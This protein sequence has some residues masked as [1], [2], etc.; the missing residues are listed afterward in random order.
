[1]SQQINIPNND[2]QSRSSN[3][4]R[5]R[6]LLRRGDA[7]AV[8]GDPVLALD[9]RRVVFINRGTAS[10]TGETATVEINGARDV[11]RN[12]PSGEITA[13]QTGIEISGRRSLIVNRGLID[14]GVNGV[15]FVN[16]GRSSGILRNNGTITSDSRAVNIGGRNITV[17]NRG[18]ILGTGDQRNG[19]IYADAT[20]ENLRIINRN[21]GVIDAGE[22]NQ[23]AG[24]ALELGDVANDVVRGTLRNR[25]T[26]QGRGQA[27]PTTGLAGDGIRL[28]SGVEGG[29]TIYRGDLFN[30]GNILSESS[31]GPTSAIRISNGLRFQGRI[32]NTATGV[33]D[34]TQNGLYFGDAEHDVTVLNRGTI[35]SASRAVNIDGTGITLNNIGSILGTGDQRNGT[36]YSD[37]TADNYTIVNTT[38]GV[39]DAG[40]TN[41]GAGIALQTGDAVGDTVTAS[42]QNAGIIQ[43]RGQASATSGQA[44]DGIRIFSG[45]VGGGTTFQ[46]DIT[47]SGSILSES[48]QGPTSAIRFSNGLSFNGTITNQVGGLI[49]GVQNGLYFGTG[50]HNA[51]VNNEGTIQSASRAVNIDGTGIILN[52][53]GSILGTGDQRNGTIYSDATADN[54]TIVNTA[55]GVVDAGAAN[56]GAGIALQTGDITGDTVTASVTNAG[57]I[58]GRGSATGNQSGDGIRIFSGVTDASTT[59]QG[60]I[61]NSGS[62]IATDA[63]VEIVDVTLAGS[64]ENSGTITGTRAA[65]DASAAVGAVTVNNQG[66]LNGDVLLG[67]GNDTYNGS[68]G[69]ING[70]VVGGAGNDSLIGG[71]GSDRL[72]GGVGND[73]LTGNGGADTFVFTPTDLGADIITDFQDGTDILDVSALVAAGA[74]D[75]N[76]L[77]LQQINNDTLITFAPNNTVLLQGIQVNQISA[78]DLVF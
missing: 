68:S 4:N 11:V 6:F 48:T 49:D 52:N 20:A 38:S 60:S 28:Y 18:Q 58:Q 5:D 8:D 2:N 17:V 42:I 32:V 24:I 61:T 59:F 46:G 69:A 37:A 16:G 23:G 53:I 63:G 40:A 25:G 51:T 67:S 73:T 50:S 19:T 1:M 57:T 75:V 54:Y 12:N 64:I 62:I 33:I 77:N 31:Q 14:G 66:T 65:I 45:V 30:R 36:I 74:I 10:T 47:N 29:G 76:N 56:N 78:T 7:T 9:N 55:S 72:V 27:D 35:Q 3:E 26:I 21:S 39:V 22:G 43:G 34:G 13:E 41:N 71:P 15:D 70:S 44:G